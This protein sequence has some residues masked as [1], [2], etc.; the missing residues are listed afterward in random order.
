MKVNWLG[1]LAVAMFGAAAAAKV[2]EVSTRTGKKITCPKCDGA[3]FDVD[4]L[5]CDGCGWMYEK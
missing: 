3:C 1:K 5:T 2:L 4:S